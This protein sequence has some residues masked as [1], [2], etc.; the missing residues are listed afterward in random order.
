MTQCPDQVLCYFE[1]L[2]AI[3]RC[4]G[5]EDQVAK[6]LKKWAAGRGFNS[7]SDA[8]GNLVIRVPAT[9]GNENAPIVIIQGHMDMVCEKT[10]DSKHD[11]TKD[12]IRCIR[13]GDWMTANDTS[14]GADNGIAIAYAMAVAESKN[15]IHPP[16]ELLFTVDEESGLTGAKRMNPDLLSGKIMINLDSEDEGVF[17]VGC[18]GTA[19]T[20]IIL[21]NETRLLKESWKY[22]RLVVSG[23]KGGHSGIDIDKHRA[24]ANKLLTRILAEIRR[25]AVIHLGQI[26]GGSRPNAI[27][28]DAQALFGYDPGDMQIIKRTIEKMLSSFKAEYGSSETTLSAELTAVNCCDADVLSLEQTDQI[29]WL[30]LALPNGVAGVSHTVKGAI[31]TSGNLATICLENGKLEVLCSQRSSIQ[32]Q[33]EEVAASVSAIADLAGAI[34][35]KKGAYPPWVPNTQS[36]LL[37]RADSVYRN[38]FGKEPQV[39]VIH[40]G[41]ECAIIGDLCPGMDM[42]SFGPTIKSP[43]SPHERIFLPSIERV[44]TLLVSLLKSYC[45]GV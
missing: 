5:S 36:P 14:L 27:P 16:L 29:I 28:R 43:H 20:E 11:F 17:I 31:E 15:I 22:A 19:D 32:S 9:A 38:L 4:S 25:S 40:A 18:S 21:E 24:N 2:N 37:K 6:W 44:W 23:L 30:L 8:A 12:P 34:P 10:P 13:Q 35:L 26:K 3:P 33:L 45:T 41:L 42:I 7:E 39:Q 1:E